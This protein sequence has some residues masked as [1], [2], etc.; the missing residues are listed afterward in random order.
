M[1]LSWSY[2]D[3]DLEPDYKYRDENKDFIKLA[4]IL[5]SQNNKEQLWR[6]IKILRNEKLE[7]VRHISSFFD[8]KVTC[9]G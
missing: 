4:N 1:R 5:H 3:P 7:T 2:D 8:P 6:K 9:S